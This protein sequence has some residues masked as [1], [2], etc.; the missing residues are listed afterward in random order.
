M[1]KLIEISLTNA[2]PSNCGYCIAHGTRQVAYDKFGHAC[3]GKDASYIAPPELL[4]FAGQ[5]MDAHGG[6][7]VFALTGGEPMA[8]P[9][10]E[11]IAE[12]LSFMSMGTGA[13]TALYTNLRLLNETRARAVNSC[14]DLVVAGYHP[15]QKAYCS[16][17]DWL[18]E[19]TRADFGPHEHAGREWLKERLAMISTRFVINYVNGAYNRETDG[20]EAVKNQLCEFAGWAAANSIPVVKTPLNRSWK[21]SQGDID[22]QLRPAPDMLVIRADG[23]ILRCSGKPEAIGSIYD[24]KYGPG[25]LCKANCSLCPSFWAFIGNE[26]LFGEGA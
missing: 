14:F 15:G 6:E 19:T 8:H 23:T 4:D 5:I 3:G 18:D 25:M 24:T 2:C 16:R 11:A 7:V 22:I 10:F 21:K 13:K 26:H 12:A 17:R 1:R 9:A 20:D